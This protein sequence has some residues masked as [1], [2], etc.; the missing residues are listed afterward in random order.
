MSTGP[1]RRDRPGEIVAGMLAASSIFVSAIALV[2]TPARLAPAALLV[3]LL[4]AGIGG[5][6]ARLAA[7][8]VGAAA[9]AWLVGMTIAI[10]ANRSL[11]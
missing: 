2:H 7:F 6:H 5:R 1:L 3:A 9:I 10:A 4:S 8:A 11:Y